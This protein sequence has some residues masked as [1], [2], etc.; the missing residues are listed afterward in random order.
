[1]YCRK[2]CYP[3]A[4]TERPID[5]TSF[6]ATNSIFLHHRDPK[7]LFTVFEALET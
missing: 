5:F 4:T 3:K 1:M 6:L 2:S 7:H